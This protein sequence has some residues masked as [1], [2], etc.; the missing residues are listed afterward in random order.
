MNVLS[1]TCETSSND[2][3]RPHAHFSALRKYARICTW[4]LAKQFPRFALPIYSIV[5][6][7]TVMSIAV[8]AVRTKSIG[9]LFGQLGSYWMALGL[10]AF[11]IY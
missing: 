2:V 11:V 1:L 7:L 8:V 4:T 5:F 10:L 6:V 3:R 9:S